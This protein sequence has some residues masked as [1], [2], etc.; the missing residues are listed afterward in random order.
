[1]NFKVGRL[2]NIPQQQWLLTP[3]SQNST[4]YNLYVDGSLATYTSTSSASQ[5]AIAAGLAAALTT[6]ALSGVNAG[7]PTAAWAQS[8][9]YV[10]GNCV[11]T[12]AGTVVLCTTS[13]TSSS[14]GTGPTGTLGATGVVDGTAHWTVIGLGMTSGTTNAV[15]VS[16]TTA[17]AFHSLYVTDGTGNKAQGTLLLDVKQL[18]QDGGTGLA[19]DLAAIMAEDPNWYC[20][21]GQY[22]SPAIITAR[23]TFA[24]ANKKLNVCGTQDSAVINHAASGATDIAATCMSSDYFYTSIWYSPS[25]ADFLDAGIAGLKLTTTPGSEIWGLSAVAGAPSTL[26][27]ATQRTNALA[28]NANVYEPV[29]GVNVTEVGKA[30]SGEWIDVVRF[31]DW[32][33]ADMETAIF[34]QLV[35]AAATNS[36][37]PY[38]DDGVQAIV[39]TAKASLKRGVAAGGLRSSPAPTVS[40]PL[41]SAMSP[42]DIQN[43]QL[44]TLTFQAYLAG[45]IIA[46][47]PINGTLTY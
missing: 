14:S 30:C 5:A 24:E 38:T 2:A 25:N 13:G 33:V 17:G 23:A 12:A 44:T 16:A 45:A 32:Q 8:T 26:L 34:S 10:S 15:V 46:V 18:T 4:V 43:R 36:K 21:L 11:V 29:A 40:V 1:V 7:A 47:S 28:K 35:T 22:D 39:G 31:K 3:T 42:T 41:V 20:L 9:P 6:L 27:S 19:A 37:V